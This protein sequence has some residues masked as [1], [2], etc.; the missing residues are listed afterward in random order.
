MDL[1]GLNVCHVID[2][3]DSTL[4]TARWKVDFALDKVKTFEKQVLDLD[5]MHVNAECTPECHKR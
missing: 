2:V 3:I 4:Q 1:M 5:T